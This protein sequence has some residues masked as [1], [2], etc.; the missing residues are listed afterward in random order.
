M[1]SRSGLRR[2]PPFLCLLALLPCA[3]T[4]A[5]ILRVAD[6]G[7]DSDG[8]TWETAYQS[9]GKAIASAT[10]G[11]NIWVKEGVYIENV[12]LVPGI[13]LY[14]GFAGNESGEQFSARN[15]ADRETVISGPS[16]MERSPEPIVTGADNTIVDGLT[17][18]YGSGGVYCRDASMEVRKCHIFNNISGSGAGIYCYSG[19]MVIEDCIFK[20]N[21]G[22]DGV[23][24]FLARGAVGVLRNCLFDDHWTGLPINPGSGGIIA[25]NNDG[26]VAHIE[27][28]TIGY[29]QLGESLDGVYVG[30]LT[31]MIIRNSVILGTNR[32]RGSDTQ[33][34]ELPASYSRIEAVTGEGNIDEDP[35]F[36]SLSER[37]YR[38][39]PNSPCIDA[40]TGTT[41]LTDLDGNPRPIDLPAVNNGPTS[42]DMGCYE[43]QRPEADLDG[44]GKVN[45]KDLLLLQEQWMDT[46]ADSR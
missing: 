26:S 32:I 41:L 10:T 14:G 12:I 23:G 27:H 9:V 13:S 42:F 31:R 28:C 45:G 20:R 39:A 17:L 36:V 1:I 46:K 37:S 8:Q 25:T 34:G 43:F 16:R 11:D 40:G 6:T 44:D 19:V 4:N 15:W 18:R 29:N 30:A 33:R 22:W 7:D 5:V 35:G 24:A 2:L 3:S 21:Q 38:L